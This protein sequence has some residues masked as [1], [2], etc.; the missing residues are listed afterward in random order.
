[1]S[2]LLES[3]DVYVSY[4]SGYIFHLSLTAPCHLPHPSLDSIIRYYYHMLWDQLQIDVLELVC[5][6]VVMLH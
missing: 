6:G 1:M 5:Y 2:R 3:A 4:T